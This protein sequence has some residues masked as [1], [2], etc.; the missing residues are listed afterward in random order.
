MRWR[1]RG[2]CFW[3]GLALTGSLLATVAISYVYYLR[4]QW[5]GIEPQRQSNSS[6][7]ISRGNLAW[8]RQYAQWYN[9][10]NFDFNASR[11]NAAAPGPPFQWYP[12]ITRWPTGYWVTV[13]L[14]YPLAISGAASI[15]L[16]WLNRRSAIGT[17]KTCGYDRAGLPP[18]APC[19]ECGPATS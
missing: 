12:T 19:P 18:G 16:W 3:S 13:S 7:S 5:R 8:S 15:G 1:P 6:I 11:Y 17:C 10:P 2:W 9:I 4:W 14:M